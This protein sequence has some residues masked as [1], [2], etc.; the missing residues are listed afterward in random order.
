MSAIADDDLHAQLA[1]LR[2]EN[3]AASRAGCVDR[4][5][6]APARPQRAAGGERSCR[7][8]IVV[9]TILVPGVDRG[10][11]GAGA[12]G[13]GGCV[14]RDPRAARGRSR[15][16]GDDHRRVDG[17]DHAQVDFDE[18]T[19]NVFD[20]IAELGLP[21]R[22]VDALQLLR[23]ARRERPAEPRHH[24]RDAGRRVRRFRR[25]VGDRHARRPPRSR[26]AAT[27]DGGGLVVRTD[28][29]VGIQ[30]GAVVERV[31]QN[32]IDRG[33]RRRAADPD[34]RQGRHHRRGRQPGDDPHRLRARDDGRVLAAVHHARAVRARHPA[35][36][37]AAAS[38]S[39]VPAS[40][41]RSARDARRG[42]AIG[43]TAWASPPAR[44]ASP[45]TR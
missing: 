42:L 36:P 33:P 16:A 18:I 30:L 22:A 45:P 14:R 39:W 27:S 38:P 13:R 24:D 12:A 10:R 7:R 20:G 6:V 35:S 3:D 17:G 40:A 25:G 8:L 5:E 19:A 1:A 32:L 31:K 44:S 11:V 2:A 34:D 29:G 15:R 28:E 23:G 43:S 21:P 41:S 9:A 4:D 26:G 37:A